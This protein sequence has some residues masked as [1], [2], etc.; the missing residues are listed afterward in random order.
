MVDIND[1]AIETAYGLWTIVD[2]SNDAYQQCHLLKAEKHTLQQQT[3][4]KLLFV[5][6]INVS[7]F[8][9]NLIRN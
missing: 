4:E 9:T 6:L 1:D 5:Q 2:K 8:D 3:H 7:L